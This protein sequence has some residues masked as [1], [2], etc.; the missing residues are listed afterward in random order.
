MLLEKFMKTADFDYH[1]PQEL[2]A[3]YPLLDREQSR[4]M[5]VRRE[6]GE[7]E[8]RR[9]YELSD[10]LE[11]GDLLVLN[12]TKVIPARL[13]G[14]L[15]NGNKFEVLLAERVNPRLWKAIMRNPKHGVTVEFDGGF[16]GRVLK[17]GK[18]EWL[19]D[20]EKNAD[21]YIERYGKMPLPPY[22]EREPEEKDR[23]LYQTVYAERDGAIAAPTAGLHFTK[24]L[25]DEIRR[26]GVEVRY[27]TL[28]VGVGTF[29]PVKAEDI[30]E[31]K[32]HPEYREIP[33]ETAL[34]VNKAKTERRRVVAVGTTVVRTLESAA[35]ESGGMSTESGYTDLFI[36]PGFRFQVVDALITNFHLPR[37]TLL[38]LVSAFTGRE[39]IFKAYDEAKKEG[40]RFLSYGDSMLIL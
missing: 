24:E 11:E 12:N 25:I 34:A 7:I 8:H 31:H 22:I 13:F 18:D 4:L 33:E 20:Y 21:D 39:V 29:R 35:D 5:V 27:V 32:M 40:Y 28:H 10:L 16:K 14:K 15:S 3:F 36:Y 38:M 17:N 6:D 30:T 26:N 9:F 2:I 37:S 23:V 1:L 19:I